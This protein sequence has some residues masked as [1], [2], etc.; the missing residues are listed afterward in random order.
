MFFI[1]FRKPVVSKRKIILIK[2][3]IVKKKIKDLKLNNR[4]RKITKTN[5]TK[6]KAYFDTPFSPVFSKNNKTL[7]K[8]KGVLSDFKK[9][10]I[11]H[12]KSNREIRK[13]LMSN[14]KKKLMK[15]NQSDRPRNVKKLG[16]KNMRTTDPM[17][18]KKFISVRKPKKKEKN[19]KKRC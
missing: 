9:S 5:P 8:T 7:P 15:L 12:R 16:S 13:K 6:K 14:K 4:L 18:L 11:K 2:K 10:K 17:T 1:G 3:E 19:R